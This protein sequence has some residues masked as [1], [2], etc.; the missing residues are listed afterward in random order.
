MTDVRKCVDVLGTNSSAA[1]TTSSKLTKSVGLQESISVLEVV[2]FS[3]YPLSFASR[4][5][6]RSENGQVRSFHSLRNQD[7]ITLQSL[8][9]VDDIVFVGEHLI[10]SLLNEMREERVHRAFQWN[11][12][13]LQ[14]MKKD[15]RGREDLLSCK[16][17]AERFSPF[18]C[19]CIV[20][21]RRDAHRCRSAGRKYCQVQRNE[22][23][24]RLR[25]PLLQ[26]AVR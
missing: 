17:R 3:I 16:R 14:Q 6:T 11:A 10:H 18:V 9:D 26:T 19:L 24:A 1:A 7:R 5:K 13:E 4:G 2:H 8:N 23:L 21:L 22:W 20:E 15:R 25:L 12:Q